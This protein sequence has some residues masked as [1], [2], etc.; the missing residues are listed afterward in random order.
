MKF[1]R[2]SLMI[3]ALLAP[4][5]AGQN[6]PK[7]AQASALARIEHVRDT[8]RQ[9][10]FQPSLLNELAV[11]DQG[12]QASCQAFRNASN[13]GE[14]AVCLV[15]MGDAERMARVFLQSMSNGNANAQLDTLEQAARTHYE[16]AAQLAGK[17]EAPPHS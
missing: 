12:L 10:G 15:G 13:E 8:M 4:T 5:L 1:Q 6:A 11:A 3:A 2:F 17:R 9:S 16:E 14:V 7:A